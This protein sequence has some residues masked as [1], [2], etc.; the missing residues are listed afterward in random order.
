MIS[1]TQALQI[2]LSKTIQFPEVVLPIE[3]LNGSVLAEEIVADRDLPP[4]HRVAMDG[5]A[6]AYQSFASGGRE[7]KIAGTQKA[8]EEPKQLNDLSNC[9]EVM[10]GAV[11]PLGTDT[12]IRY[13]DVNIANGTATIQIENFAIGSN[14]HKQGADKKGGDVL[15]RQ[16]TKLSP[17][18]IAVLASVGKAKARV[19]SS[20][21]IAI[22]S[23]GDELVDIVEKPL[24][25]QIRKS[26]S[27][28]LLA[29]L[30]YESMDAS[31]HHFKDDEAQLQKSF[32]ALIKDYD[33]LIISGG[34]SKGKFDFIPKTLAAHGIEK[35]FHGVAQKP[36]KPFWF[37]TGKD[38]VVFALPGNPVSTYLCFYR[39]I[40]PW[41]YACRNTTLQTNYAQLAEDFQVKD[42]SL[43]HFLQVKVKNEQGLLLA[44][45]VP[46]GGSGDHA[47]LLEVDGFLELVEG[48]SVF[49]SGN[50]YPLILFR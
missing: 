4:Y 8:G 21:K 6:I 2:V 16:G 36:G 34:V 15:I 32:E 31:L 50:V 43:T 10:T 29:A 38:K 3:K 12:V 33:V 27:Y 41:I 49:K 25:H 40:L 48:S 19:Y 35:H 28:A 46:G 20:P 45:P 18:D 44:Y 26:N 7:F 1:V 47:N 5:I 37:G 17:A 14:V 11:L 39:Y 22:V 23:T 42:N 24:A 13:E 9:L 30:K